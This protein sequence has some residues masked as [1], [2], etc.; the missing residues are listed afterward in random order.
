MVCFEKLLEPCAV[1]LLKTT[2]LPAKWDTLTLFTA[3]FWNRCLV[4]P[5]ITGRALAP[6][7]LLAGHAASLS[8]GLESPLVEQKPLTEESGRPRAFAHGAH[9]M[10]SARALGTS[11]GK[12]K[13]C[14]SRTWGSVPGPRSA[15]IVLCPESLS[16]QEPGSYCPAATAAP[17]PAPEYHE[18]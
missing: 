7:L 14:P 13:H 12:Q 6:S 4:T 5:D 11:T 8:G 1:Q 9:T 18:G 17:A 16:A 2:L 15:P 3:L 10:A